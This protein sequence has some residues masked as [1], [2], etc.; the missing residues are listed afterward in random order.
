[1]F[2]GAEQ[3]SWIAMQFEIIFRFCLEVRTLGY[4]YTYL[5]ISF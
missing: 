1:M 5:L 3:Y 2:L 4:E